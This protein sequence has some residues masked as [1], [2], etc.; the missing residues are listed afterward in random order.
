MLYN[1]NLT[2][3]NSCEAIGVHGGISKNG[4]SSKNLISRASFLIVV[5]LFTFSVKLAYT[6]DTEDEVVEE[7]GAG[8]EVGVEI[9][10]EVEVEASVDFPASAA[11]T[12][13]RPGC[14]RRWL[15]RYRYALP[16]GGLPRSE[17]PPAAASPP[18]GRGPAYPA[19]NH[20][21]K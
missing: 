3:A 14:R 21:P 13:G 5:F 16:S 17:R 4:R 2:V 20:G 19:D 9:E 8:V 6:Q 11:G 15:R 18:A 10:V 12:T 7:V 1:N